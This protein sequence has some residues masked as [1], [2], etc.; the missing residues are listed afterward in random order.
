LLILI[1]SHQFFLLS[2]LPFHKT[3]P[4]SRIAIYKILINF[5]TYRI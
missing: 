2:M 5:A 4:V 3:V 1:S